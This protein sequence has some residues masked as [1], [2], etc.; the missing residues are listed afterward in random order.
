LGLQLNTTTGVISGV[1]TTAT[2]S[3]VYTVT[4]SNVVGST[5]TNLT[6]TVIVAPIPTIDNFTTNPTWI[7]WGDS[8]AVTLSADFSSDATGIITPGN[9]SVW[10]GGSVKVYTSLSKI[11]TLTVT[12]S[13]GKKASKPVTVQA[14]LSGTYRYQ[15]YGAD[16]ITA[17]FSFYSTGV[18]NFFWQRKFSTGQYDSWLGK[19]NYKITGSDIDLYWTAGDRSG[20]HSSVKVVDA[21][22]VYFESATYSK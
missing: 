8:T 6:I 15:T 18:G 13:W 22:H 7:N 17:N 11:Y 5:S 19:F 14:G 20:T 4:A 2:A 12:N 21:N 16:P 9:L 3:A 1:P 10:D